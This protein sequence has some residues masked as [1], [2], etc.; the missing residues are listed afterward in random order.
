MK[1]P[2]KKRNAETI[3]MLIDSDDLDKIKDLNLI[4]SHNK[5]SNTIYVKSVIYEKCEYIKTIH[6]HRLIMNLGDYKDDKRIV[7]HING[8][9]FDNR[10]K[11]LEICEI[12]H[13]N[14]SI[15]RLNTNLGSIIF[16]ND[17]RRKKKV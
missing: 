11:N 3:Y 1:Y 4:Q 2:I 17:K 12:A 14:L 15:N 7:N 13:N 5:K 10:K 16:E 8:N 6:I 9:G